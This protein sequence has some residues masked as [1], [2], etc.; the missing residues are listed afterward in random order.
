MQNGLPGKMDSLKETATDLPRQCRPRVLIIEDEPGI[1]E[2]IQMGL[3]YEGFDSFSVNNGLD[4]LEIALANPPDLILLDLMLPLLNGIEVCRKV[5]E[6]SAVP[7]IFLSARDD[8]DDRV[9]GLETGA[10][11]YITKPFQFKELVARM[12][13]VLRRQAPLKSHSSHHP[14]LNEGPG[15]TGLIQVTDLKLDLTTREFFRDSRLIDLSMREFELLEL[16][17][18]HPNQVLKRQQ[19]LDRIWGFDFTGDAN[20]IEVYVRYLR[21][22]LGEPNVIQTVRGI[23]YALRSQPRS[24]EREEI[25]GE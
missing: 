5:R 8:L 2:F 18:R 21:N 6:V 16:F 11:D 13:A 3:N 4:G 25:P 7:I 17:L 10:D 14:T 12:R 1:V 15:P 23:G 9:L 19:I 24:K 22:K 20:I